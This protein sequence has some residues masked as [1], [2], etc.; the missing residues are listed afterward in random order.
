MKVAGYNLIEVMVVVFVL[1]IVAGVAVPACEGA[2]AGYELQVAA[3]QV[4]SDIRYMQNLSR[5]LLQDGLELDRDGYYIYFNT[6]NDSYSIYKNFSEKIKEY[7]FPKSVDLYDTNFGG[8]RIALKMNGLINPGGTVIIRSRK[9]GKFLY[10]VVASISGRVRIS[11][12]YPATGS[13]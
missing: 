1:G 13:D 7:S 11:S 8:D 12:D 9:T 10:V 6:E 4:V 2:I 3:R 5:D